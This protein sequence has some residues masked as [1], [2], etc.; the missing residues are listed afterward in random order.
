MKLVR[1]S[2]A[3]TANL[4][5]VPHVSDFMRCD[6][7]HSLSGSDIGFGSVKQKGTGSTCNQTLIIVR[8]RWSEFSEKLDTQFSIAPAR[9]VNELSFSTVGYVPASKSLAWG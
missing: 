1:S 5:D 7:S 4:K 2:D 8:R 3:K 6:R 9:V